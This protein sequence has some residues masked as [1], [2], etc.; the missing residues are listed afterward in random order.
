LG[1]DPPTAK[2]AESRSFC[3]PSILRRRQSRLE[4]IDRDIAPLGFENFCELRF[5]PVDDLSELA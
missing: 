3:A 5:A 4:P 1:F 2:T